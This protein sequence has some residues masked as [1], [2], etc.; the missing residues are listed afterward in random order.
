MG[1][2]RK[3][4]YKMICNDIVNYYHTLKEIQD[5]YKI[6]V[7]RTRRLLSMFDNIKKGVELN[8]SEL[9]LKGFYPSI[10]L[11]EKVKDKIE[12]RYIIPKT[13]QSFTLKIDDLCCATKL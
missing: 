8:K 4:R 3:L 1:I 9:K 5:I 7:N 12:K 6:S 2:N 10:S 13:N 11:F